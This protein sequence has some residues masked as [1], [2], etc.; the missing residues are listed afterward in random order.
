[1]SVILIA[2]DESVVRDALSAYFGAKGYGTFTAADGEAAL[3]IFKR[4]KID[5]VILDLMLPK[6]SGEEVCNAIRASS[7]V[8][9]LML[10]AKAGE[11]DAVSGL[12]LGADDYVTKPFSIR[13]LHARVEAIL[14][15]TGGKKDVSVLHY[16]DLYVDFE[17]HEV[18]VAGKNISL[19]ALEWKIFST[20]A[21][22]PRKIYTRAELLDI[23]FEDG[24]QGVDRVIDTHIKNIRRKMGGDMRSPRYI[25]TVYGLGY[26]FMGMKNDSA[27]P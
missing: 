23:A 5:F 20:L 13:E 14:R 22:H 21:R 11:D 25:R 9:I 27:Q 26:R 19:T 15:R 4:E 2:D 17:S 24:Y 10:T 1:M 8:P 3:E 16:G 7:D 18:S 6:M 12:R